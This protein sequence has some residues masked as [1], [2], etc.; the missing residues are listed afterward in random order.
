LGRVKEVER[1]RELEESI[2]E[3]EKKVLLEQS[4]LKNIITALQ[5]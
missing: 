5:H 2:R 4:E 3:R 1:V